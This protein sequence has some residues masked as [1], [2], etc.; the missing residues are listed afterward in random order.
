MSRKFFVIPWLLVL[1]FAFVVNANAGESAVKNAADKLIMVDLNYDQGELG[2]EVFG[3]GV[4]I[5]N[6][7][8]ITARH[9]V[10][11]NDFLEE[12]GFNT[13][14][15]MNE[16]LTGRY[17]G[18]VATF[19]FPMKLKIMGEEDDVAKLQ[20]DLR[21]VMEMMRNT[22][23]NARE[24]RDVVALYALLTKG[25]PI[26]TEEATPGVPVYFAGFP[27]GKALE[28]NTGSLF[29]TSQSDI[30]CKGIAKPGMSGGAM[31]ND[32]GAI[33]GFIASKS[34]LNGCDWVH[35]PPVKVLGKLR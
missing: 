30:L 5:G 16:T 8:V 33:M 3:S 19:R 24:H 32:K 18:A 9:V 2:A 13:T 29:V 1:V 34:N 17:V 15:P 7:V 4:P 31:F 27:D 14:Q 35:G 26:A 11:N 23:W 12:M 28:V 10:D 6:G 22:P 25:I 21:Y 20:A